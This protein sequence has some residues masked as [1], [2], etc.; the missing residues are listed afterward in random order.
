MDIRIIPAKDIDKLKWDSCVHYA[1]QP[2]F[3]GY[4]W[5][6]NAISKD[7]I[8]L[9]EGDYE[10]VMPL[11]YQ[12][13]WLGRKIYLQPISFAP[14]GPFS[15][16]VMSR[17]RILGLLKI[18]PSRSRDVMLVWEGPVGIPEIKSKTEARDLLQLYDAYHLIEAG[19]PQVVPQ[20]D[21]DWHFGNPSPEVLTAFW[22][23]QNGKQHAAEVD[24]HRYRRIIYQAMHRGQGFSIHLANAEGE[25]LA[26]AYFIHSHGY[27]YRLISAAIPGSTGQKALLEVFRSTIET[28]AGRPIVLDFNGVGIGEAFGATRVNYT[29][30]Q[31]D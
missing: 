21:P 24:M 23:K 29:I 19:F 18:V 30:I 20:R 5:Y 12:K 25:L 16:H 9:V 17:P 1:T 7:W 31:K 2:A 14:S 3:T 15:I 11:F 13:D 22:L 8:G 6:L 27:L 26:M 28:Y 10:T 4:T